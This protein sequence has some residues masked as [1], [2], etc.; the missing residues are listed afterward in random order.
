M[1]AELQRL[2]VFCLSVR[3]S[4]VSFI[5]PKQFTHA[6]ILRTYFIPQIGFSTHYFKR[7]LLSQAHCYTAW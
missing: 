1:F 4:V 3:L 2:K 5:Y 7:Y 6:M